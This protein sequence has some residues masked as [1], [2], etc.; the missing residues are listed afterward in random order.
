M[1][2]ATFSRSHK[3]ELIKDLPQG[4]F[5]ISHLFVEDKTARRKAYG[6][7]HRIKTTHG[8]IYRVLRFAPN[9]KGSA[10]QGEGEMLID[11]N[12]WLSLTG[13]GGADDSLEVEVEKAAWW[14]YFHLAFSHPDPMY[15]YNAT[16]AFVG[17]A[18][19]VVSLAVAF[20][21]AS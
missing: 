10:K 16:F 15:R 20:L 12:G 17:F 18:L 4:W 14:E 2:T 19:G 6:Q 8:T 11:W 9:L 21:P 7:W 3:G 13:L 5:A 1:L